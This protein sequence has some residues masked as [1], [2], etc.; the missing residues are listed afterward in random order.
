MSYEGKNEELKR[1]SMGHQGI[2]PD[3]KEVSFTEQLRNSKGYDK[4]LKKKYPV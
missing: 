2:L 1:Q 4:Y 3:T